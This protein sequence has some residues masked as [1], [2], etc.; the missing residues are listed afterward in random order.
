MKKNFIAA[1]V[2]AACVA[3]ALS[4]T[5][6][7]AQ[8]GTGGLRFVYVLKMD[9]KQPIPGPAT[10]PM[11]AMAADSFRKTVLPE[12]SVEMEFVTDGQSVRSELHGPMSTLPKG[13]V[14]LFP[15]GQAD[16]YVLNPGDKTYFVLKAPQAPPLPP[17]VTLPKP[18]VTVKPS[19]TFETIAGVRAEKVNM[20][21]RMPIP[22][23]DGFQVPA[24]MPKEITMEFENYCS[25]SFKMPAAVM[26]LMGG[27][28][29]SMQ[30]LGIDALT[31]GCPFALRSRMRMSTMPGV[32]LVSDITSV[33]ED[34]PAPDLF[35]LPAGYREVPPPTPKM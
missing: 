30:G 25:A 33:R 29:Q 17:G 4:G 27:V 3:V 15:A 14:V 18:E 10:D 12:G 9:Q 19:G 8:S 16:G 26:R 31:K 20:S 11:T 22:V 35:K 6:G 1:F 32:E 5:V 7:L 2:V 13:S 34:K 28:A 24:G 21:W 23:P